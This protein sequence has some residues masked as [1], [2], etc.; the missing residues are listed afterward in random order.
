MARY[1]PADYYDRPLEG[2]RALLGA[3]SLG[4]L[5]KTIVV[6]NRRRA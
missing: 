6:E 1:V 4:A 5:C 2:R 3:A